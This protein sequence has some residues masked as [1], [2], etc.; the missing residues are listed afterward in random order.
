MAITE[1]LLDSRYLILL[2]CPESAASVWVGKETAIW[3]EHRSAADIVV[4]VTGEEELVWDESANVLT[5]PALSEPVRTAI[6]A[7]P[8]WVDLRWAKH[9]EHGADHP[10]F[11][12]TVAEIAA[13]L[14]GMSK[15]QLVGEDLQQQRRSR[16]IVRTTI[17][18]LVALVLVI[19]GLARYAVEQRDTARGQTARAVSQRVAV[20]SDEVRSTD[21]SLAAQLALAAY[22]GSPTTEAASSMLTAV[23]T[24]LDSRALGHASGVTAV[25]VSPDGAVVV[26]GGLDDALRFWVRGRTGGL[27]LA[28]R[29]TA[30]VLG[31]SGLTFAPTGRQLAVIGTTGVLTMVDV[32]VPRLPAVVATVRTRHAQIFDVVSGADGVVATASKDGTVLLWDVRTPSR[33]ILRHTLS[34]GRYLGGIDLAADGRTLAIAYRGAT[35]RIEL[36]DVARGRTTKTL[37]VPVDTSDDVLA[38]Y[39]PDGH[40]LAVV[41][42]HAF[43]VFDLAGANPRFTPL[44]TVHAGQITVL[45]FSTDGSRIATGS[46]DHLVVLWDAHRLRALLKLAHPALVT[47]LVFVPGSTTVVTAADD[48]AA[49]V[50]DPD[51]RLTTTET[52]PIW[53]MARSA[54]GRLLA[55]AGSDRSVVLWRVVPG[56]PIVEI[57]RISGLPGR[58]DSLAPTPDGRRVIVHSAV[59]ETSSRVQ[60]W[61]VSHP[62]SPALITTLGVHD[63]SAVA[64]SPD[65]TTLATGH[66]NGAV[67]LWSASDLRGSAPKQSLLL[68]LRSSPVWTLRFSP[69]GR[70]LAAASKERATYLWTVATPEAFPRMV[71]S[72]DDSATAVAFSPDGRYLATGAPQHDVQIWDVATA[73][74]RG[75]IA[76]LHGH[77][78]GIYALAFSPDGRTLVSGG[79]DHTVIVWDVAD[80]RAP[81]LRARLTSPGGEVAALVFLDSHT[82]AVADQTV[83]LVETSLAR[84]SSLV[85]DLAGD[86]LTAAEWRV[87][88]PEWTYDKPC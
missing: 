33:P 47:D 66:H 18:A 25:A 49:R 43:G 77:T 31:V 41:F 52:G 50:W 23:S 69:D 55:E 4:V 51:R 15:V 82:V 73:P 13:P 76:T 17:A 10:G 11:R 78:D 34:T 71:P 42:D 12:D 67:R 53:A 35:P 58:V 64:L 85:C 19:G 48:G 57:G 86:G 88:L 5:G 62:A 27:T 36:V 54:D 20:R 63:V 3:L 30:G 84:A 83:R 70:Q 26:T 60:V 7:Q 81:A 9:E 6:T 44:P 22:R 40:Q 74:Y 75:P 61:D 87:Y 39:S 68:P 79:R 32:R 37:P 24:S 46:Q 14:H 1:A 65:G 28:A 45:R 59:T 72:A 29:R 80:L 8:R 56:R 2:A 38:R 16:R 21:P